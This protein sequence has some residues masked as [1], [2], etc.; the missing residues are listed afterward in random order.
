[1]DSFILYFFALQVFFSIKRIKYK[2]LKL[3]D[4]CS[5]LNYSLEVLST[6]IDAYIKY[7]NFRE[8]GDRIKLLNLID[9]KS[10]IK[11]DN[12]HFQ[13]CKAIFGDIQ[14]KM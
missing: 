3:Q 11:H 8:L 12:A 13:S 10:K 6:K 14:N 5:D 9:S 4:S 2:V 1:L 7:K